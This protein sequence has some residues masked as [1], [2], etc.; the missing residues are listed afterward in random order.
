MIPVRCALIALVLAAAAYPAWAITYDE[1][2]LD[3][4]SQLQEGMLEMFDPAVLEHLSVEDIREYARSFEAGE[5]R[6][7]ADVRVEEA[8]GPLTPEQA[9]LILQVPR[10]APY[11]PSRFLRLAKQAYGSGVFSRLEWAV[12]ENLDGSVDIQLWYSSRDPSFI[13]PDIGY[14]ALAGWQ[15]GAR[16]ENMYYGGGNKR[17][18][19]GAQFATDY[20]EE[21]RLHLNWSDSTLSGGKEGYS[22]NANVHSDWR[23]RLHGSPLQANIR[24]RTSR[25]DG[26][27]SWGGAKLAGLD[28]TFSLGAGV[29]H[30]DHFV[31]AGDPTMEGTLPRSNVEQAGDAGFVSLNWRDSSTDMIFTPRDGHVVSLRA[32]QHAGDFNF[33]SASVDIR[34]YFPAANILGRE[35]SCACDGVRH[36]IRDFFPKASLA[37]Q[38]QAGSAWGGVPYSYET[39][40]GGSQMVRGYPSDSYVG[41]KYGAARMEYRFSL[42]DLSQYELFVYS[43]HAGLGEDFSDIEGFH[44]YGMGGLFTLPVYGGIKFGAYYGGSYDGEEDTYGFTFGY[45]F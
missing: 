12:Y 28:G 13:A 17:L 26:A 34:R 4:R 40:L 7:V 6:F 37:V 33:S 42:D 1:I 30:Q 14:Y 10:G 45:Q 16:Y 41:T 18:A 29:Y 2:P 15:L 8:G 36:D 5:M 23:Q 24:Q 22:L 44:T 32:E 11:V 21:P 43:D 27:Y 31:L 38:L 19:Y 35:G 39:R 20:P 25:I 3:V 9:A